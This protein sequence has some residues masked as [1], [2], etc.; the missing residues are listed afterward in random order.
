MV[1]RVEQLC[2]EN[3][4]KRA[5]REINEFEAMLTDW[6]AVIVKFWLHID[7][8]TQFE[9]FQKRSETPHKQWKITQEDWRNRENWDAYREAVDEMLEKTSTTYAPWTIVEANDKKYA[10]IKAMKTVTEAIEEKLKN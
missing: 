9:R 10:R 8:D 7:Q 2:T 6:N 5:Y 1:E 3:E 4:W